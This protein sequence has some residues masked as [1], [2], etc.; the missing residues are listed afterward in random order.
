MEARVEKLRLNL[1]PRTN[2]AA[3]STPETH[4]ETTGSNSLWDEDM[5][6]LRIAMNIWNDNA[7]FEMQRITPVFDIQYFQVVC[8]T[9]VERRVVRIPLCW[10]G[11]SRDASDNNLVPMSDIQCIWK[12]GGWAKLEWSEGGKVDQLETKGR[13]YYKNSRLYIQGIPIF[14][15]IIVIQVKEWVDTV[16]LSQDIE[17]VLGFMISAVDTLGIV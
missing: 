13:A 7:K 6:P 16:A 17:T 9:K 8:L 3:V 11:N 10:D 1:P 14:G 2:I 5:P 12:A 15:I 4:G